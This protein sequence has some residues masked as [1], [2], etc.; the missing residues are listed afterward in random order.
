M[1][2]F[3]RELGMMSLRASIVIGVV[4][5][6]RL[7]WNKLHIA[8]KY[9]SVLWI[10]P[11]LCLVLPWRV[12]S[13]LS[14]WGFL[15]KAVDVWMQDTPQ[16]E[17]T[18]RTYF[19]SEG[20][21]NT[22]PQWNNSALLIEDEEAVQ[23]ANVG[24]E[25]PEA[26][27]NANEEL[28]WTAQVLNTIHVWQVLGII[29]LV[30]VVAWSI[31]GI[32]SYVT[33]HCKVLCCEQMEDNI[34]LADDIPTPFVLGILQPKIYVPSDMKQEN[35]H[36]VIEHERTHIMRKDYLWKM[37][38]FAVTGVHWFNPLVWLAF[39]LWD[40]DIEMACD[41]ETVQ[42]IGMDNK[43]D[44]AKV[45]LLMASGRKEIPMLPVAFGEGD[46]KSR[47][48][49]ILKD[50]NTRKR[51]AIVASV[52]VVLMGIVFLTK[53]A[54]E[55]DISG[56]ANVLKESE[57]QDGI[58]RLDMA[59]LLEG[60]EEVEVTSAAKI[61][62]SLM[63]GADGVNLDYVDLERIIFHDYYGLFVYEVE[64]D[65]GIVGSIDLSTIGCDKTQGEGYCE[66]KVAKDGSVVWLKSANET[67]GYLYVVDANQLYRKA[68]DVNQVDGFD[69]LQNTADYLEP[70]QVL[71][72]NQCVIIGDACHYLVSGSGL[73][74]DLAWCVE[75][76]DKAGGLGE[77]Q[78]SYH[79]FADY[80]VLGD[81]EE[82]LALIEQQKAEL[83]SYYKIL[84]A[85]DAQ[86]ALLEQEETGNAT[87]LAKK[88]ELLE[89]IA[90]L[91][92]AVADKEILEKD[93]WVSANTQEIHELTMEELLEL[94]SQ[95]RDVF[96]E[97]MSAQVEN[98]CYSNF[99]RNELEGS[100]TWC[101]FCPLTYA[102]KEYRLQVSYWKPEKAQEHAGYENQLDSVYLMEMSSTDTQV[103]YSYGRPNSENLDF[104]AFLET[105][106]TMDKYLTL[107]LPE[108]LTLGTYAVTF[109]DIWDGCV[110][111]GDVEEMVHGDWCPD[112]WYA[113]GGVG[114][115]TAD[116]DRAQF[117][118]GKL[119]KVSWNLNHA[120]IYS[121]YEYI[122]DCDM[123]AVLC[124]MS[125]DIFLI[126]E[127][128]EYK[129]KYNLSDEDMTYESRF[130]YVF[131]A[132]KDSDRMYTVFLNQQ[133]YDK[134]DI[135]ALAR[136]VRFAE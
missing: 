36:Y 56:E 111:E 107:E 43:W 4:L 61:S 105:K 80:S 93:T 135:I 129:E 75:E 120:E 8:K 104:T 114:V 134:E 27:T 72:S 100:L 49:N 21:A 89:E 123:Q 84:E 28:S 116:I 81:V 86:V 41:E 118:D 44:Y 67:E 10:V 98:C 23:N 102:G 112:A 18:D 37:L 99:E 126:P 26:D 6:L 38:G 96:A 132:Q 115:T 20:M 82:Q 110:F 57:G 17:G 2:S 59:V 78:H 53:P 32:G 42:R 63:S 128:E 39:H 19:Y 85:L 68:Y 16:E 70:D 9:I 3:I 125:F 62:A 109:N 29:W 130:W 69:E 46:T 124:E 34:Y 103:L 35:L 22:M 5:L 11:F 97:V 90:A 77:M 117:T 76:Y 66:V 83:S 94:S 131:F 50:K 74:I 92:K 25:V 7:L 101:Y 58:N 106:Y 51:I 52:L 121:D 73:P 88:Q 71:R 127:A 119:T 48:E 33:L 55:Q 87:L 136:S 122:E 15:E 12:E 113:P 31:Y 54:N 65:G 30:G 79:V 1:E 47:I 95:G 133:Y 108:G 91:K 64:P 14:A 40:K 60:A 24:A 45:L 13:N